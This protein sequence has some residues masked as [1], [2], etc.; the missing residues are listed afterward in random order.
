[1]LFETLWDLVSY[2]KGFAAM[3]PTRLWP[4]LLYA[5][6]SLTCSTVRLLP[7]FSK[8]EKFDARIVGEL[9]TRC[10]DATDAPGFAP[11]RGRTRARPTQAAE[12]PPPPSAPERSAP[13][14]CSVPGTDPKKVIRKLITV[15]FECIVRLITA[16]LG[17]HL[18]F[19]SL[20]FEGTTF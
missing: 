13:Q 12:P 2:V 8:L 16:Y 7:N 15:P 3:R 18:A 9:V 17:H 14:R 4:L 20:G 1:M 5:C 11:C 19:S 10:P 6:V